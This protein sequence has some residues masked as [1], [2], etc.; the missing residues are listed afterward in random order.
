[1][2]GLPRTVDALL[3][4]YLIFYNLKEINSFGCHLANCICI[5]TY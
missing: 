4:Q 3:Y 5:E 1:M 2:A